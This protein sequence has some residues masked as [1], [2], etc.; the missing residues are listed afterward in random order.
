MRSR[1][2]R[3][4]L[5]TGASRHGR[6]VVVFLAP[7]AGDVAVVA[8]RRVGGA[9]G[10]NRARRIVREAW[11]QVASMAPAEHDAVVVARP[12]IMGA[13]TQNLVAEMTELL[14]R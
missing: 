13:S 5:D 6:L 8:G 7:G 11:R 14:Q 9:V 10:R 12:D 1:H 4:V 3:R 2:V